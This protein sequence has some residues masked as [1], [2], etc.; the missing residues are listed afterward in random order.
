MGALAT[1]RV[2]VDFA[3]VGALT[4]LVLAGV[5][6]PLRA[7]AGFAST[8]VVMIGAL[9]VVAGGLVETGAM[10]M[11][12]DRLLGR[13]SSLEGAQLR[14]MVPVAGLSAFMNN[15]PIVAMFVPVISDWAKR[16]R[17]S[18]SRLLMPLS[19]AA[20]LGGSCTLIGTAPNIVVTEEYVRWLETSAYAR[21]LGLDVLS[22]TEQMWWMGAVGLPVAVCGVAFVVLTTRWLL[23]ERKPAASI[24]DEARKFTVEM[25]VKAESPIVGKTIEEAG[26][27]Q[28]PGLYLVEIEREGR[29]IPAPGPGAQI[30]GGDVLVFVGVIESVVDL[31]KIR[32]LVP[33]TD[34]VRKVNAA[35]RQRLIVEAVVAERAPFARR[36]VR[37]SRFRSLYNAAIIAV[38]RGGTRVK[39]KIGD[40][41]LEAGDVLLLE[42]GS[43]F[44]ERFRNSSE[45]YLVSKVDGGEEPH[46]ER[47]P[48]AIGIL[49]LFVGLLSLSG[50]IDRGLL[51]LDGRL[52]WVDVP[53]GTVTPMTSALLCACLMVATRCTTSTAARGQ[54]NWQVLLAV[55]AA[56]GLGVA[57][58]ETGAAV[59]VADGVLGVIEPLGP[60]GVLLG[61]FLLVNVVTQFVTNVAAAALM[62]PIVIATAVRMG[63]SPEPFV[64]VLMIAAAC[65]F[66]TPVGYQTNL[67]VFGPGGY[68]FGD[69]LKMG[70]PLT[71]LCGLVATLV[72]PWVYPFSP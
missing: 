2:S 34:Q 20:I 55:G 27:R 24:R 41:R 14:M 65:S 42:A 51:W 50:P 26:L 56:L 16:L 3:M 44:V 36:T 54:I 68:R 35:R 32:G 22:P 25:E 71:I 4:L 49:L 58:E 13:P 7:V 15:T 23:A 63:V 28:L 72:A 21:E 12:V 45:F 10:R 59:W 66:A 11:V 29:Q 40:I 5:V 61:M 53:T 19:F 39:G 8:P 47:A 33:A 67:M 37:E 64:V 6:E 48:V 31:R 38:H 60:H 57:M 70:V 30:V 62:F 43:E 9:Y 18:P 1:N 17:L 69:F 52:G 46:F